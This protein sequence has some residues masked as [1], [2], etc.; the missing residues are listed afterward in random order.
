MSLP[1]QSKNGVIR[2]ARASDVER[3]VLMVGQLADHH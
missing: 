1:L 3:I 2:D